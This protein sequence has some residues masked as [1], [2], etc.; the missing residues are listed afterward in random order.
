MSDPGQLPTVIIVGTTVHSLGRSQLIE[1]L[2]GWATCDSP[3]TVNYLNA[4]GINIASKCDPF[5]EALESA[6]L[7]FCDGFGIQLAALVSGQAIPKRLPVMDWIDEALDSFAASGISLFLV[8]DR[9]AVV[10]EAHR[11]MRIAHPGLVIAGHHHGYFELGGVEERA[12]LSRIQAVAPDVVLVG[13][14]MPRQELWIASQ[15]H[16][17]SFLWVAVGGALRIYSGYERRSPL[18]MRKAGLEWLGRL[19]KHPIKLAR[20]YL[21]GNVAFVLRVLIHEIRH[22]LVG[23]M[24]RSR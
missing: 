21:V 10:E 19:A 5:K 20:R 16:S 14:G 6:D 15:R 24:D 9:Q 23:R 18:W 12:L 11:R 17:G 22:N 13:M 3:R 4:H 7:A 2:T 1:T 8:G